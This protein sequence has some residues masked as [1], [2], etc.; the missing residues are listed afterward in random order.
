MAEEHAE[1]FYDVEKILD[2]R[3]VGGCREYFVKWLGYG[4]DDSSWEP[5]GLLDCPELLTEF[6]IPMA[7]KFIGKPF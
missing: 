4:M 6:E 1:I 7:K 2:R 5:E 3:I